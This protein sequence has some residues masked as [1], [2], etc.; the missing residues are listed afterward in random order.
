MNHATLAVLS[1]Q[2]R[3]SFPDSG[4]LAPV[5]APAPHPCANRKGQNIPITE[6]V[7]LGCSAKPAQF[8]RCLACA[9]GQ[10]L[11]ATSPLTPRPKPVYAALRPGL[12]ADTPHLGDLAA[13]LRQL[14]ADGRV[15]VSMLDL[16]RALG[17]L[18]YDAAHALTRQAGLH[19][20]QL[21]RP[22]KAVRVDHSLLEFL[23]RTE[24]PAQ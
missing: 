10:R 16:M 17:D 15:R 12:P 13:A 18:S 14:T 11:A 5:I 9:Q 3:A 4:Y 21:S 22:V 8:K 1:A 2:V 7:A 19:I 24:T 6:C 20:M 23:A